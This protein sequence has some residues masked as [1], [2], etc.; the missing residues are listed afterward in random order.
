MGIPLAE[1]KKFNVKGKVLV[2]KKD[3]EVVEM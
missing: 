2:Y 1:V 3:G